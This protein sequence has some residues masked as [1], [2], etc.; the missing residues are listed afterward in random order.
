MHISPNKKQAMV[1]ENNINPTFGRIF[2]L[3]LVFFFLSG[4]SGLIYEILWTRMIIKVIGSAPFAVSI[5]LTIFM[6]GLGLGSYLAGLFIDGFK[7]SLALV[8][9]YGFLNLII[10]A[11]ALFIPF[12]IMAFNPLQTLLYNALYNHF[13]FYW[14]SRILQC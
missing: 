1:K 3:M 11:Y 14:D 5:I 8:K 7:N 6:G 2:S 9:L 12:L 13:I 10:G 4:L